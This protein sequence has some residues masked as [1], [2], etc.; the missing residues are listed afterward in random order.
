MGDLISEGFEYNTKT[1]IMI[2]KGKTSIKI[3][4]DILK[5]NN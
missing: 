3:K 4:E 2:F 5:G 1:G